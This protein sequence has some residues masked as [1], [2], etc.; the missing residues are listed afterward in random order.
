MLWVRQVFQPAN[1]VILEIIT[2]KANAF[3]RRI[4]SCF[5]EVMSHIQEYEIILKKWD[6]G[7]YTHMVPSTVF[8]DAVQAFVEAEFVRLRQRK[9]FI[10]QDLEKPDDG[11]ADDFDDD[12]EVNETEICLV[13][14][15][16][17]RQ[18]SKSSGLPKETSH[19]TGS[20]ES[21]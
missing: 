5:T 11:I 4:P 12:D 7:D 21:R 3:D 15:T 6:E 19:L 8:N 16:K 1:R 9:R 18:A 17:L 20:G 13:G 10:L 14:D 2:Y